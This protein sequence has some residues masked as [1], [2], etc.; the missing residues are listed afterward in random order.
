MAGF[1]FQTM[2]FLLN[3][4]LDRIIFEFLLNLWFFFYVVHMEASIRLQNELQ[5]FQ[6]QKCFGFY[7]KPNPN[8]IF[9]WKCQFYHKGYFF[10]LSMIFTKDYPLSPPRIKFDEKVFHPNVF[11][12]NSICLDIISSKWSPSLTIKDI[13]NGLKQLLDFP[14]PNSPA[15]T[16]AASLYSSDLV[17]YEEKVKSFNDKY[18]TQYKLAN[19]RKI[20]K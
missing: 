8:N 19:F 11:S 10:S 7:A 4:V 15:N 1:L 18:H 3:H 5:S 13:L 16:A 2:S 20:K 9:Q 6:K 17:K 14:N 12:D